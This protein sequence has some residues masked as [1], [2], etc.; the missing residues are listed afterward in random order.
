[1]SA[2]SRLARLALAA[3][4]ARRDLRGGLAGLRVFLACV[5]IGV[6]AI[7]AVGAV[8][9]S[10]TAALG[11]QSRALIGG[12]IAVSRIQAPLTPERRAALES[13]GAVSDVASLRA[14]ARSADSA[15]LVEIKAVDA[16]YPLVGAVVAAPERPLAEALGQ[17]D[18]MFGV[19]VEPALLDRLGVAVGDPLLLGRAR[20]RIVGELTAEPDRIAFGVGFGPR[21]LMARAALAATGLDGP[22]A[23]VRWSTRLL[24][25]DQDETRF[26]AAASALRAQFA[27]DGFDV[28]DRANAAPQM[29]RALGR[30]TQFMAMIGLVSLIVGG[31]GVAGAVQ[32]FVARKRESIA[33]LKALGAS[34]ALVFT[35]VLMEMGAVALAGAALGAAVGLAA[36]FAVAAAMTPG[37]LPFTPVFAPAVA[38]VGVALGL[39]TAL[40]FV[41]AP[42]GRAHDMPVTALFRPAAPEGRRPLRARY[43]LGATAA[44]LALAAALYGLAVDK[45]VA[46]AMMAAVALSAVVLRGLAAAIA[47]A[48]GR[49]RARTPAVRLALANLRRADAPTTPVV[50]A[51]GLG[52]TLLV[53]LTA[54]ETN[55]RR[56]L[57][58][59]SDRTPDFFFLDVQAGEAA[60]FR[61]FL[62]RERPDAAIEEAPMLRG[63]ITHV[64]ARSAQEARAD[65]SA[66]WALEGDRG[67]T[68]AAAPPNGSRVVAGEWWAPD[69]VGP[70][71]IS[72]DADIARGLGL[73]LGDTLTVNVAGRAVTGQ[74]A[75]LRQVDWRSFGLNF[76]LVFSPNAF[77]GAPY[78]S[79]ITLASPGGAR[80]DGALVRKVSAAFPAV[81]TIGVR[82]AL[83]VALTMVARIGAAARVAAAVT[84]ATAAL[85]LAGAVAAGQR[86]RQY[87]A[88]VLRTLGARRGF[89]AQTALVEF[90]I[91]GVATTAFAVAA[92]SALAQVVIVRIMRFDFAPDYRLA[93]GVAAA[94]VMVALGLGWAAAWR[95]L[96]RKPARVLHDL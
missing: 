41:I 20:L 93:V 96:A 73:A 77:A 10:L 51:L 28:R 16:A 63:R 27:Q 78:V 82:D 19:L 12:D 88:A 43:G 1:M 54:V 89:L 25:P 5:A 3:R 52:L 24:L 79:L 2:P 86:A 90:A 48:S 66:A 61:D 68:F 33:V 70:P 6:A 83:D 49:I 62:R 34:G 40:A 36:P 65:P 22:G 15:A 56:A 64:G 45:R 9:Q 80:R 37:A 21:I 11:A 46:L 7:V 50:A 57:E 14:M 18:G 87:D 38:A 17:S 23:L 84:L 32:A 13:R 95:A 72:L 35:I 8:S 55:V 42:A 60:A 47:I 4:L 31:V 71:L 69:Y 29:E 67:V 85:V 91:L 74:I 53:A 81:S 94:G 26:A 92:G 44:F 59:G 76:V 30:F 58:A 39:A 75:N